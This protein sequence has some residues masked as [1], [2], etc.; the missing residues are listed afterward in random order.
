MTSKTA[1]S[2]LLTAAACVL[3]ASCQD[4]P[5]GTASADNCGNL[6]PIFADT[7]FVIVTTPAPGDNVPSTF[8]VRGCSRTFE[9][10]VVWVLFGRDGRTLASGFTTGGGVDGAAPFG[11]EVTYS[12]GV[13]GAGSLHVFE[14]DVSEGEGFPPSKVV[15]PLALTGSADER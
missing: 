13:V 7:S 9:S 10:N 8:A 2:F 3:L 14:P 11:F 5:A 1:R 4:G 12:P 6:H 15:I